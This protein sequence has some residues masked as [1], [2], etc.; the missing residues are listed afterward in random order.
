MRKQYVFDDN[1]FLNYLH[2]VSLE[3]VA[4]IMLHQQFNSLHKECEV[5]FTNKKGQKIIGK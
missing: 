5:Q 2:P 4:Y 1:T 3:P